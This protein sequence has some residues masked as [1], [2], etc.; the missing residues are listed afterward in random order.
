[1][2]MPC[3]ATLE[4]HRHLRQMDAEDAHANRAQEL[5]EER[6]RYLLENRS[7]LSLVTEALYL[8]EIGYPLDDALFA[9]HQAWRHGANVMEA[10]AN[11]VV[12]IREKAER[13]AHYWADL[14]VA[15]E[16]QPMS[17]DDDDIPF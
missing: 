2:T 11:V 3:I 9:L 13:M 16:A 6:R 15:Q 10:A 1:M 4:L 17:V 7:G 8:E 14:E 12:L 5:M